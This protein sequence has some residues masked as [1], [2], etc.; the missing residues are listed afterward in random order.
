M[1]EF[2]NQ[3]LDS[4]KNLTNDEKEQIKYA[5][6]QID[7]FLIDNFNIGVS[8]DNSAM[9]LLNLKVTEEEKDTDKAYNYNFENNTLE[10]NTK[11]KYDSRMV[12]DYCKSI[13]DIITKKY[14]R[15]TN[16][17]SDGLIYKD[18]LNNTFG[19]KINE[20][21]KHQLVMLITNE[22]V[23]EEEVK[24]FYVDK[25]DDPC[26]LED[27]LLIDINSIV[28]SEELINYFV[29]ADGISFYQ[30]INKRLNEDEEKTKDFFEI[31]DKYTKENSIRSRKKY[32]E[33][34]SKMKEYNLEDTNKMNIA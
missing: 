25:V 13:L 20:K 6:N 32:D 17:Y 3:I 26:T 22:V 8:V 19:N 18:E 5:V 23:D 7:N 2:L 16:T 24:D 27:A 21:L 1:N 34:I 28:S 9:L 12:Y 31:I 10:K 15:E 4:N 14:D 29:N 30:E 33:L 11:I